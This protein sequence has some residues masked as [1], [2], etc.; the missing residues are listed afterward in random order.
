MYVC[1]N[2]SRKSA[3]RS[4][5]AQSRPGRRRHD[6]RERAHQLRDGVRVERAGAAVGDE[7]EVARVVAALHRDE[8]QR[9]GH[10]LVDDREDPL[11]RLLDGARGRSR[12]RSSARPRAPRRRRGVISPPS[13]CGGRWPS[14]TFASVTVGWLAA[15]AVRGRARARRP[16]TRGPTRSAFVSCGTCAI[17]PP[18]APTVCT[19]TDGTRMRKCEIAVS[20]PIDGWP[21]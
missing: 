10:V 20:R 12:R 4:P 7:R 21:F 13:S 19:S 9:A 5:I 18:P 15:P 14:T 6:H 16:P 3:T 8:P 2:S 1:A 17:E 11:G